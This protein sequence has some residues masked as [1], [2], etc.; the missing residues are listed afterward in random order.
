MFQSFY[1]TTKDRKGHSHQYRL[2]GG[3]AVPSGHEVVDLK[4]AGHYP[5]TAF[6]SKDDVQALKDLFPN[7]NWPKR[8]KA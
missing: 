5:L 7:H 4:R 6:I 1:I 2:I 8:A 3:E